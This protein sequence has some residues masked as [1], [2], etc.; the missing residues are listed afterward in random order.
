V[1]FF[2]I[3]SLLLEFPFARKEGIFFMYIKIIKLLVNLICE[4]IILASYKDCVS[5]PINIRQFA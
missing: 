4:L 1:L 5:K 3:I 2:A